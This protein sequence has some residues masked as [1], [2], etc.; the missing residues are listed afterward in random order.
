L[1]PNYW[2]TVLISRPLATPGAEAS[3]TT[4]RPHAQRRRS[5]RPLPSRGP[6]VLLAGFFQTPAS[7]A[8]AWPCARRREYTPQIGDCCHLLLL[9]TK[10]WCR[11]PSQRLSGSRRQAE[12]MAPCHPFSI[13][14]IQL[15]IRLATNRNAKQGATGLIRSRSL[16]SPS[17]I[18]GPPVG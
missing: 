11:T 1:L 12:E 6:V 7:S 2:F 3:P 18:R 8:L 15:Q 14:Q 10:K 9:R 17:R 16:N 4:G 13:N 5:A